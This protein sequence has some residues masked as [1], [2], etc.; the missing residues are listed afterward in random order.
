MRDGFE[1]FH[2][3]TWQLDDIIVNDSLMKR[4][5]MIM[6]HLKWKGRTYY[7]YSKMCE[8]KC[9]KIFSI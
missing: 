1:N 6:L 7:S 2:V 8:Y 4:E 3:C 9:E 5:G